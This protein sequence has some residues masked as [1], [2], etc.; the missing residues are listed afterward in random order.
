MP[1]PINFFNIHPL[2]SNH[3]GTVCYTR[4]FGI[5]GDPPLLSPGDRLYTLIGS[6]AENFTVFRNSLPGE[7]K[8]RL[9]VK[10]GDSLSLPLEW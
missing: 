9:R 3:V 5:A 7:V 10:E 6:A 4:F 1:I 8:T 2:P